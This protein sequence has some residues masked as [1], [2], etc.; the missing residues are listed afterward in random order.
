MQ[1][2][3]TGSDLEKFEEFK[4]R[5][6]KCL[7]EY[8][9][10]SCAQFEYSF[11]PDGFGV[12]KSVTCVCGESISLTGDYDLCDEMPF[13]GEKKEPEN[14]DKALIDMLLEIEK[15]P[16]MFFLKNPSWMEFKFFIAGLTKANR[17]RAQYDKAIDLKNTD[18]LTYIVYDVTKDIEKGRL[19]EK[20]AISGFFMK[21][22]ERLNNYTIERR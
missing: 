17:L 6:E 11:A 2:E 1:F 13:R 22:H 9:N 19:A 21:L 15:R 8:P 3:I 7:E 14:Y 12:F 10:I 16:A 20:D 18:N 4:V 5:H